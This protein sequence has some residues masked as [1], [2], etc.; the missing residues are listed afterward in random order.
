MVLSPSFLYFFFLFNIFRVLQQESPLFCLIY[1]VVLGPG[2]SLS[3]QIYGFLDEFVVVF[4]AEKEENR[5]M[6]RREEAEM[7]NRENKKR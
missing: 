2:L 3:E 5:I 4:P 1:A 7:M 6:K